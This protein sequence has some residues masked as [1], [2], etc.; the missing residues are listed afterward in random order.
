[1]GSIR[2][3]SFAFLFVTAAAVF[4]QPPTEGKTPPNAAFAGN[5]ACRTCH[6]QVALQFFRN[7][8]N[9]T[10]VAANTAP[11]NAGCESCHGSGKKHV[12]AK[13]GKGAIVAFSELAPNQVLDTCLRCHNK[14]LSRANIRRSSHSEANVVC[15]S[16]HSIHR[17]DSSRSL[18]AKKQVEVCY[19]CHNDVRAQF[20]QP[21]KHRVNEG[22]MACSDCH[23][24]HGTS[25]GTW[26]MGRRPHL[27][28]TGLQNEQA[29]LKC[30]TDKRGPFLYEH[31]AVRV[32]GCETCHSPHGSTNARLL[33]RP[34]TFTLCLECHNGA[35]SFG[36]QS[37]GVTL[38]S[39]SHNMTDPRYRNCTT[40]HVRIHGSNSDSRFLR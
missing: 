24:P 28:D 35:G 13:G 1:M 20:S 25:G 23:N 12:D 34:V 40:C 3:S 26:K 37:D 2:A 9:K 36:R 4:A 22:F 16:C 10:S 17:A 32:D 8:H 33:K 7:P 6:P 38:Q 31:A 18:L 14:D 5:N 11:E 19:G 29:C 39:P 15:T 27:V 30:H 21:F